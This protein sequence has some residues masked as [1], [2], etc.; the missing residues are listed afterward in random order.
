MDDLLNNLNKIFGEQ[1]SNCSEI[2]RKIVFALF[3]IIWALSFSNGELK[4]TIYLVIVSFLLVLYLII[5]TLQYFLTALEYRKHFLSI[6]E[7]IKAGAPTDLIAKSEREKR[8]KINSNSFRMMV[9][10]VSLLPVIFIMLIFSL[11][12]KMH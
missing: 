12:N 5:D 6:Q 7:A 3:A 2:C 8:K 11:I 4:F 9:C 1:T 10:K